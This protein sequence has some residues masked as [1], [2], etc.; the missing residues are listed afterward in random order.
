MELIWLEV[1]SFSAP[2]KS[3]KGI[4]GCQPP[5]KPIIAQNVSYINF[6]KAILFSIV[7]GFGIKD[8]NLPRVPWTRDVMQFVH[9]LHRVYVI[10]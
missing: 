3:Q 10:E 9:C 4:E 7:E 6:Q 2:F 8:V 5:Q 1:E